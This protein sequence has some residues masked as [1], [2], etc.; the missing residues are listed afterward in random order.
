MI[1]KVN[2]EVI[3]TLTTHI[4]NGTLSKLEIKQVDRDFVA[5]FQID[6]S[7]NQKYSLDASA[8]ALNILNEFKHALEDNRVQK[9][10][11]TFSPEISLVSQAYSS[12]TQNAN[13]T[14]VSPLDYMKTV[15]GCIRET[16]LGDKMTNLYHKDQPAGKKLHYKQ[17]TLLSALMSIMEGLD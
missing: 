9:F 17:A 2:T 11:F 6:E 3:Q 8:R 15:I 1:T 5:D 12:V 14:P 7:G 4:Q 13:N 10:S 16:E